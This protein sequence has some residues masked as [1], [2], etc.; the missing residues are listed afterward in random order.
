MPGIPERSRAAWRHFAEVRYDDSDHSY[1]GDGFPW[2]R[3]RA[4]IAEKLDAR[5]IALNT[6]APAALETP[7]PL[8]EEN[9]GL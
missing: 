2:F 8:A 6:S 1:L 4:L 7:E 9:E 3:L 5:G